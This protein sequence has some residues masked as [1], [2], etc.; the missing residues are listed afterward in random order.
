[1]SDLKNINPEKIQECPGWCEEEARRHAH[2]REEKS[3]VPI[4]SMIVARSDRNYLPSFNT[5][6]AALEKIVLKEI[7]TENWSSVSFRENRKQE[8]FSKPR[9]NQ[10]P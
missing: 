6:G 5:E 7:V 10:W 3:A 8:F 2:Q 9:N 1:M 4:A